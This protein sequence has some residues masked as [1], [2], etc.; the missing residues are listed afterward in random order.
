MSLLKRVCLLCLLSGLVTEAF[1]QLRPIP[2]EAGVSGFV[3][4]GVAAI[5]GKSNLIAGNSIGDIGSDPID[6]IFAKPKSKSSVIPLASFELA[7]TFAGDRTQIFAGSSLED[8]IRFDFAAQL[9]VRKQF[10][11]KSILSVGYLLSSIPAEVWADPYVANV[12]RQETDRTSN[13]VRVSWGRIAGTGLELQ[14][15]AREIEVDNELSGLTGGLGL[16]APEVALLNREGD[17][18]RFKVTYVFG[19]GEK[20]QLAPAL[21]FT[22]YDF[23]G[24]AMAHDR[25]GIEITH[26]Y[27]GERFIF[28]T[29]VALAWGDYDAVNPI[30]LDKRDDERIGASFTLFDRKLFGESKWLGSATLV[31]FQDDSDIDFYDTEIALF[32]VGVFRRF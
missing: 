3:N 31:F 2:E 16:S 30:Y 22:E 5:N 9:G 1:A 8:F 17:L 24:D 14:F 18:R 26:F 29:N 19:V 12:P 10:R 11:N 15:T 7:Y 25:T 27:T 32:G 28:A 21:L 23:D 6:S 13:G 20:S 4:L